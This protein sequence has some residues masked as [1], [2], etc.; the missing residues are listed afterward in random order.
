MESWYYWVDNQ[1]FGPVTKLELYKLFK[2][3]VIAGYS[4]VRLQDSD[5]WLFYKELKILRSDFT[6]EQINEEQTSGEELNEEEFNQTIPSVTASKDISDANTDNVWNDFAPHPWRRY[7][8]RW[9]DISIYANLVLFPVFSHLT[10]SQLYSVTA[11]LT[12]AE[13]WGLLLLLQTLLLSITALFNIFCF[14][15]FATTPGKFIFGIKILT[16]DHTSLNFK[17]AI[18]REFHVLVKGFAFGIPVISLITQIYGYLDLTMDKCTSW[19]DRLKTVVV[20]R[21]NSDKQI[22]FCFIGMALYLYLTKAIYIPYIA[23]L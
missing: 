16:K 6:W 4:F 23:W 14:R 19:D 5:T 17:E 7:F 22:L 8:A 10:P 18:S 15:I 21:N 1:E 2:A 13:F 3:N 11:Q 20:Q 9:I 12:L